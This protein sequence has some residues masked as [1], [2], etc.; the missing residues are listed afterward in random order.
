MC[1]LD[2]GQMDTKGMYRHTREWCKIYNFNG[3]RVQN[4]EIPHT[5]PVTLG[6]SHSL[7]LGIKGIPTGTKTKGKK[8]RKIMILIQGI[9]IFFK[10]WGDVVRCEWRVECDKERVEWDKERVE[11]D[12]EREHVDAF[13]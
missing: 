8:R 1:F 3:A 4:N 13:F 7:Q 11:C 12:K 10:G 2:M 9:Q 5:P 6:F